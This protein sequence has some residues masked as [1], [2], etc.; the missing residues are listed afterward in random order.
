M[1]AVVTLKKGEGRMIK[2]RLG[3][4]LKLFHANHGRRCMDF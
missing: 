1:S 2:A 3:K 4:V